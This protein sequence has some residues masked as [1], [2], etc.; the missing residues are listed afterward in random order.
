MAEILDHDVYQEGEDVPVRR[1]NS[2]AEAIK[3]IQ[4]DLFG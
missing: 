4:E 3:G 2:A 1:Y